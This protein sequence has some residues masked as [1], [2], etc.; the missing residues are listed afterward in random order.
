M[1]LSAILLSGCAT[2]GPYIEIVAEQQSS[3]NSYEEPV[4][5]MAVNGRGVRY[6]TTSVTLG[7]GFQVIMVRTIRKDEKPATYDFTLPLRAQ[8]CMRY[9]VVARHESTTAVDPWKAEIKRAEP[10]GECLAIVSGGQPPNK[11]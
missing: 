6:G 8:P 11:Q 9:Y 3:E 10:I 1:T 2:P 5:L 7:P 4:R